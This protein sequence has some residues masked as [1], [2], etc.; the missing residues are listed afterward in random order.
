MRCTLSTREDLKVIM[1][2]EIELPAM[3]LPPGTFPEWS[4][5]GLGP[6]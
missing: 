5:E 4:T 2:A 1:A 3:P 6:G